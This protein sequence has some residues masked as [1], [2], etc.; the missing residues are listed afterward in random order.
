MIKLKNTKYFYKK[1]ACD[2]NIKKANKKHRNK[3]EREHNKKIEREE[4]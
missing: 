4:K 3:Q 1:C 2:R